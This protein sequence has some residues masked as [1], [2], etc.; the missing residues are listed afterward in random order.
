VVLPDGIR[1]YMSKPWFLAMT[2]E[3]EATPLA[4]QINR[5]LEPTSSELSKTNGATIAKE[6]GSKMKEK[7]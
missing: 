4:A 1:N 3:A 2:M 6:I 7:M 5:I